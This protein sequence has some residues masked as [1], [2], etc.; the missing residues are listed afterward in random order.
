MKKVLCF[1][2]ILF[3]AGSFVFSEGST[4]E[5]SDKIISDETA[6]KLKEGGTKFLLDVQSA[7]QK[8]GEALDKSVKSVATKVCIG[9]W[10]FVNG[11]SETT[12][13]CLEDGSMEVIQKSGL[14]STSWRGNYTANLSQIEFDVHTKTSSTLFI[15]I[16]ETKKETWVFNY[17]IPTENMIRLS[18]EE[19]PDDAN[20]YDFSS[21]TLFTLVK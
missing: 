18:C 17:R 4:S 9:S 20:G 11:K 15:K 7:I 5:K 3:C 13:T 14:G 2:A 8:A 6:E 21:P 19:M 1:I 10:Q 12:V 16:N